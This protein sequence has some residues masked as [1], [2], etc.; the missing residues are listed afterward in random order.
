MLIAAVCLFAG[1]MIGVATLSSLVAARG[2]GD[3]LVVDGAKG[4]YLWTTAQPSVTGIRWRES[5]L[6]RT[7]ARRYAAG[8]PLGPRREHN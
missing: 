8:D 7:D 1:F 6:S 3:G 4:A 2:R 5:V